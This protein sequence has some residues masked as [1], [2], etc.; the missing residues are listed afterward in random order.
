MI[1]MLLALI[2]YLSAIWIIIGLF[3]S[4]I[5]WCLHLPLTIGIVNAVW[6]VFIL[7]M[8]LESIDINNREGNKR[9]RKK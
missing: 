2:V 6:L 9:D 4:L 8:I 3:L 7:G 5:F 1:T